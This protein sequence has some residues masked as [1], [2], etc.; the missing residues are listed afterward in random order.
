MKVSES[1]PG[2]LHGLQ[3]ADIFT[4]GHL[5]VAA[6]Y[7]RQLGIVE[8]VNQMVPSQMNLKPGLLVQAMVLDTL[9]GRT[10]LYRIERF[11]AEQDTELLLG[12]SV[13]ASAFND[14]NLARGLDAIFNAGSSKILTQIGIQAVKKFSLDTKAVSYDTTSTSVWGD[15]LECESNEPPPGPLITNGFSKDHRP[16]LKQFM[17]ELLCV[18]RG[19]PIFGQTLDGNSSDKKSNNRIL[20]RISSIMARHGLGTGAFVYVADSAMVTEDNL[21]AIGLNRFITRLPASYKECKRVIGEAVESNTWIELG[22][23]AEIPT[24]SNRP[25]ARYKVFETVVNLYERSYRALVVHSSSHDKRQQKKLK[26]AIA[27]SSKQ[28][29]TALSKLETVYFCE[30][31][32]KKAAK[33]AQT[34]SAKLHC[35]QTQIT[36]FEVRPRGRP[37]LNAPAKT[38]TRYQLS[39]KLTLD[40]AAVEHEREMAGSFVL[41]GN[42]PLEGED[43]MDSKKFLQTYKGQYGV[44]SDFAFL[45]DPL[46]VNDVFIKKPHRIDALGMILIIAL[47][48]WRLMERSMRLHLKNN[49]KTIEG[50]RRRQTTKPTS[51]MMTTAVVG[52]MVAVTENQRVFLRQPGV[53]QMEFLVAL[54]LSKEVFIDPNF[55]CI[56]TITRKKSEKG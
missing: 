25:T 39:W 3:G 23:L 50:W 21:E 44:E 22:E 14:T 56:Q 30:A 15:Y 1:L 13:P 7:C 5:P 12:T 16:D 53:R 40:T 36:P 41:L 4:H 6:A 26:K 19:V 8:L 54:G 11:M 18:D 45:K 20:S 48:V 34:L 17:T 28:I 24:K 42:V 32:A 29:N 31:D 9:S 51:F 2:N 55:K 43:G 47:T 10:P 27:A 38:I 46:I 35:V 52:I 49:N 37:S 33:K